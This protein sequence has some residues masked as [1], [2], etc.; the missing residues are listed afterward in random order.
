MNQNLIRLRAS[1]AQVTLEAIHLRMSFLKQA[2][3]FEQTPDERIN[4][5]LLDEINKDL[6]VLYLKLHFIPA[7]SF[8]T[9]FPFPTVFPMN[10]NFGFQQPPSVSPLNPSFDFQHDFPQ[11]M[12]NTPD[13]KS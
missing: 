13:P 7:A 3:S 4:N 10:P 5:E 12:K 6:E 2:H 1:Q 11:S 9:G 8:T